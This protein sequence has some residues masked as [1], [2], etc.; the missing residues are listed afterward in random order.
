VKRRYECLRCGQVWE[1][2][3]QQEQEHAEHREVQDRLC[4]LRPSRSCPNCDQIT[5]TG[6]QACSAAASLMKQVPVLSLE[7][8]S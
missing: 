8:W 6:S 7:R 5:P 3:T 1:P 4:E 2:I